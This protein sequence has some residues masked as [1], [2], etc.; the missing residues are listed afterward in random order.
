M[1]GLSFL[2]I[3][4]E[5]EVV[6]VAAAAVE[7][8]VGALVVP[9]WSATSVASLVILPVNAV[10]VVVQEDVAAAVLDIAG[11]HVLEEGDFTE[12]VVIYLLFIFIV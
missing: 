10:S 9:I 11:A 7:G 3:L 6:V 1:G 5:E 2:T 12:S 4:E 8:A